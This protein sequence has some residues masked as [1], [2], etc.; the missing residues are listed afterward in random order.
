[1]LNDRDGDGGALEQ[2]PLENEALWRAAATLFN[3]SMP[4]ETHTPITHNPAR[5]PL[6]ILGA[7]THDRV[8]ARVMTAGRRGSRGHVLTPKPA[9][10]SA[11]P[12]GRSSDR[13]C[14]MH[15]SVVSQGGWVARRVRKSTAHCLQSKDGARA[16]HPGL[17]T[18]KGDGS[19]CC[20]LHLHSSRASCH[21]R[22]YAEHSRCK[23]DLIARTFT[24]AAPEG[25]LSTSADGFAF[26]SVSIQVTMSVW[27]PQNRRRYRAS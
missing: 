18:L 21:A 12:A 16:S 17:H 7:M 20:V 19:T 24:I 4:S 15:H 11:P 8:Y 10:W 2:V 3:I 27:T 26:R 6:R 23:L 14:I 9:G 22:C 13:Q 5:R 1:M 25:P